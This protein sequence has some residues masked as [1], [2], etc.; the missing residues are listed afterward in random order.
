MSF[1]TSFFFFFTTYSLYYFFLTSVFFLFFSLYKDDNGT[2]V[3]VKLKQWKNSI[4]NF[5]NFMDVFGNDWV[6]EGKT[7]KKR[8]KLMAETAHYYFAELGLN[9]IKRPSRTS[10]KFWKRTELLFLLILNMDDSSN[11]NLIILLFSTTFKI[12]LFHFCFLLQLTRTK[13]KK[14]KKW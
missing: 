10:T 4:L 1:E 3:T 11:K 8:V 6:R 14:C 7:W 2:M 12:A 5:F 13:E 9:I